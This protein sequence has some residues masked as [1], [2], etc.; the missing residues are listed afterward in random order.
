MSLPNVPDINPEITLK[1]DEAINL[2]L[3]SIA[4]EEIGISHILNAEGEKIQY[5][6][7]QNPSLGELMGLNRGTERLLRSLIKKEMLLQFKLENIMDMEMERPC[8]DED[9]DYPE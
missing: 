7:A 5:T 4:L 9:S 6:L 8:L 3:T 1:R 2:L